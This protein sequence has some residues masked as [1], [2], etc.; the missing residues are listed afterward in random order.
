MS[1]PEANAPLLSHKVFAYITHGH[2][3]LVFSHPYAPSAGIQVPAGTMRPDEDPEAAVMRE[4]DEETGL[5]GL[6]LAGYLGE[7]TLDRRPDGRDE[8]H[9]RR[10]YHLRC[11]IEPPDTWRHVERD[12]SDGGPP[13]PFD[14]FWVYLPDGMPDLVADHGAFLPVLLDRL[15]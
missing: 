1:R 2:R 3:L 5:A 8:I 10:F 7:Q 12:P 14:L 9:H 6:V 4:A 13:I 11:T 15:P